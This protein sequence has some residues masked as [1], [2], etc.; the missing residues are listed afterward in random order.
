MPYC[1]EPAETNTQVNARRRRRPRQ[2]LRTLAYVN[3]D[4]GNGGIIRD[5]TD[6]GIAVHAVAALRPGQEV[7]LRFDLLSPRVRVES[8][9]RVAW[10]DPTG[11][12]GIE[13]IGASPRVRRALRDWLLVQMFASAA[14][15]G[16]DS[17]FAA[18]RED[19]LTFSPILQTPILV[20]SEPTQFA[21][22]LPTPRV[23]WA[24]F[25]FS[26]RTFSMLVDG[27]VLLCAVLL[28]S[29]SSIVV[30]GGVPAWPLA[31]TL[32]LTIATI[33]MALYQIVFSDF[34]FG[35][36][37]GARLARIAMLGTLPDEENPRFR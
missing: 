12:A 27:L 2:T 23:A 37:P 22:T 20:A 36:T 13:F 21:G 19:E 6:S 1:A 5:L 28:F 29:I 16:R 26:E 33:F 8:R 25:R 31:A 9:G 18:A 7:S 3:L 14:V 32:L 15:S 11:Q 30:M 34:L 24:W 4:Q 17:I 10:A 35:A